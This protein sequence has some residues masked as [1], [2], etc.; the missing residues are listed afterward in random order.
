MDNSGNEVASHVE[1][2]QESGE[3]DD[4]G[5]VCEDVADHGVTAGIYAT[6]LPAMRSIAIRILV[7]RAAR[8]AAKRDMR[9]LTKV[10]LCFGDHV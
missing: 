5:G 10:A 2:E 7:S 8:V 9:W 6:G 4:R 3:R 1:R